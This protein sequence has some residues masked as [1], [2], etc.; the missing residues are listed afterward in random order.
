M[1]LC[2]DMSES[3]MK[4]CLVHYSSAPGGIEVLIPETIKR[5]SG[6]V[7]SAFVIRPPA[8]GV[9]NVYQG[10]GL[11]VR[12]GSAGNMKAAFRLWLY[13]LKNRDAIFHAFNTGP[14]FMLAIRLAG[15][16]KMVYSIR[17]TLHYNG[18]LQKTVRKIFW[19]QAISGRYKFIANSHHSK[20]VFTSFLPKTGSMT[21]VIYNPL[22]SSRLSGLDS[23]GIDRLFH[24]IYAGR[25]AEGKNLFRWL[26]IASEIREVK[27]EAVFSLY[28]DGPLRERLEEYSR[29]KGYAKFIEFRG[30]V[31]EIEKAYRQA[32]LMLFLSEYESF[33]NVVVESVL[34]GTPV[35]AADIPSIR[36]IFNNYPQFLVPADSR[37]GS[38]VIEK[39]GAIEELRM[40]VEKAADEFRTRF[41]AEQHVEGLTRI[42]RSFD[43]D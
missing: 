34:C 11:A 2:D 38:V 12:Y 32:D 18:A 28:G 29:K 22:F 43:N 30:F 26:D 41:S 9:V 23:T 36:E 13:A 3:T 7:F 37:M 17:G 1:T 4:V 16:R 25:L 15:V 35:L 24:V 14:Y 40:L 6:Y 20:S 21:E 33:G 27:K 5:L 19:H 31:K 10:T 42:Y 39:I 8:V